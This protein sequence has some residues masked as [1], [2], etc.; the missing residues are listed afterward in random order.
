L[1]ETIQDWIISL[2][3]QVDEQSARRV[4]DI[5]R[6]LRAGQQV[7]SQEMRELEKGMKGLARTHESSMRQMSQSAQQHGQRFSTVVN[8]VIHPSLTKITA[9]LGALSTA[10]GGFKAFEG[11]VK[12]L[13]QVGDLSRD[14]NVTALSLNALDK[15]L[16]NIGANRGTAASLVT[17]LQDAVQRN[18]GNLVLLQGMGVTARENAERVIE[19]SRFVKR[20]AAANR[21]DIAVQ[22]L[23]EIGYSVADVRRLLA[24]SEEDYRRQQGIRKRWK[25]DSADDI[26]AAQDLRREWG[27]LMSNMEGVQDAIFVPMM[28]TTARLVKEVNGL[29]AGHEGEI[30]AFFTAI[31]EPI[32]QWAEGKAQ[33]MLAYMSKLTGPDGAQ[34]RAAWVKWWDDSKNSISG[35]AS[36]LG[37]IV[38]A[39]AEIFRFLDLIKDDPVGHVVTSVKQS[40]QDKAS[41]ATGGLIPP[42]KYKSASEEIQFDKYAQIDEN[43]MA[44]RRGAAGMPQVKSTWEKITDALRRDEFPGKEKTWWGRFTDKYRRD[45]VAPETAPAPPTAPIE[46]Y[47]DWKNR[48]TMGGKQEQARQQE[49]ETRAT[50]DNTEEIKK[51]TQELQEQRRKGFFGTAWDQIKN[52]VGMGGTQTGESGGGAPDISGRGGAGGAGGFTAPETGAGTVGG[53]VDRG[54]FESNARGGRELAKG[55]GSAILDAVSR[56]EGTNQGYQDSFAHQLLN[57]GVDITKMSLDEVMQTQ[58]QMKGSSAIGR[59]QFMRKTLSDLRSQL[60]LTGKETFNQ[61]LQDRLGRALLERRG[62]SAWRAGKITDQQFMGNLAKEWAGVTDASGR[63]VHAGVGLNRQTASTVS[64]MQAAFGKDKSGYSGPVYQDPSGG[65]G[66][67]VQ[68]GDGAVRIDSKG[69]DPRIAEIVGAAQKY[70]PPGY[71]VESTSGY[72]GGTKQSFHGHGKANDF[73]IVDPQGRTILNR[74]EDPTGLYEKLARGAYTEQ[75]KRYPEL[76]GKFAWGGAFGTQLGGGGVRDLMHF[77]LGGERGRYQQYRLSNLG[78]LEAMDKAMNNAQPIASPGNVANDNSRSVTQTNEY[79]TTIHAQ[80]AKDAASIFKGAAE[81]I[82][83]LNMSQIKGVIR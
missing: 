66:R 8:Q 15:S 24:L 3:Y 36:D 40:V 1:A 32:G 2:K 55:A 83:R 13:Q 28:K 61:E 23:A 43:E 79:K 20:E 73:H 34:E 26:K 30:R 81:N 4:E 33:D 42:S 59:Y 49:E 74:G 31:T 41:A 7:T 44:R 57:K 14:L 62:Y 76:T 53:R 37:T 6:R 21:F 35:V 58:G 46:S 25:Q 50:R 16:Q 68:G 72:R 70:L 82:N 11:V 10:V 64:A 60:G 52:L 56:A 17:T 77:D 45:V 48:P 51:N 29:I 39:L 65:D 78:P 5:A 19:L 18:R 54:G 38:H 47:Q 63:S 9:A 12:N 80:D 75:L 69:A 67:V 71:K 22:R 27:D